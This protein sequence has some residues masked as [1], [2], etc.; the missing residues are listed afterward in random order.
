[1]K[2]LEPGRTQEEVEALRQLDHTQ[3]EMLYE[4]AS[5]L[6]GPFQGLSDRLR[7]VIKAWDEVKRNEL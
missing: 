5:V 7:V 1:M 3:I 2:D 4:A 6:N